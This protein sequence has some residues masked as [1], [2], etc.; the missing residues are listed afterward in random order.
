MPAKGL[1]LQEYKGRE[2]TEHE[3]KLQSFFEQR[4]EEHKRQLQKKKL[5]KQALLVDD[6]FQESGRKELPSK[7]KND[8]SSTITKKNPVQIQREAEAQKELMQHKKGVMTSTS[9]APEASSP[10]GGEAP[11]TDS[12]RIEP[13]KVTKSRY[14]FAAR[15][16]RSHS[17][18]EPSKTST[19]E[20]SSTSLI[21]KRMREESTE[22][23]EPRSIPPDELN[24][25]KFP[26][27]NLLLSKDWNPRLACSPEGAAKQEGGDMPRE[28]ILKDFSF[29]K[30]QTLAFKITVP[31]DSSRWAINIGP[32]DPSGGAEKEDDDADDPIISHSLEP[33][34][35]WQNILY[36]F[37]PRYTKRKEVVQATL[38]DGQWTFSSRQNDMN[39]MKDAFPTKNFTLLIQ[40]RPDG[41]YTSV[42]GI[43]LSIYPHRSDIT[44][45]KH[46]RL[47]LPITD[48]SGNPENAIFHKVWW[49]R[50]DAS[51]NFDFIGCSKETIADRLRKTEELARNIYV[52]GLPYTDNVEKLEDLRSFLLQIFEEFG[53]DPDTIELPPGKGFARMKLDSMQSAEDAIA[54]Y[55]GYQVESQDDPDDEFNLIV[56]HAR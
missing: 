35:S 13:K 48:D 16:D 28:F 50:R 22:S 15:Q 40:V 53:A 18:S 41:F 51:N 43:F 3:V 38:Q 11:A 44:K 29:L 45:Y 14:Q 27:R 31:S 5:K 49:G 23:E 47:Q 36:H 7:P 33:C 52:G 8:P 1:R 32:A 46:L 54:T 19:I 55:H 20:L 24:T 39:K 56:A 10:A 21:G 25:T 37:N 9:P 34:H 42:N 26:D 4:E 30:N 17:E 6:F 12:E 2:L